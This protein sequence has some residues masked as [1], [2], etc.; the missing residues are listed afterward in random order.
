MNKTSPFKTIYIACD[1][2]ALELKNHLIGKFPFL[3]WKDLGTFTPESVDYPDYAG[4]LCMN[5]KE[6]LPD[7]RGVLICGS[8]QGMAIKA[9]RYEFI[10]AAL[11]WN[12]EIAKLSRQHNDANV[13]CMGA[14]HTAPELAET[15]LNAF[16]NTEFEG[17]RHTKRVDKLSK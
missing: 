3:P 16:L 12:E 14:R 5:M 4:Q 1:H 8:G 15:I 9:N 13:L 11:C 2:A 17:G 10:R 7:V 6:K